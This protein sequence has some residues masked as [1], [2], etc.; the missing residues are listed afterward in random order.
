MLILLIRTD[1]TA[2]SQSH[3]HKGRKRRT[4]P[5]NQNAQQDQFPVL[6]SCTCTKRIT[7]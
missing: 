7:T 1:E 3:K 2:T 5:K 6:D 4:N